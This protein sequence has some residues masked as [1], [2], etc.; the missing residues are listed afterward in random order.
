MPNTIPTSDS[1]HAERTSV[2]PVMDYEP[3]AFG[4]PPVLPPEAA[5]RARRRTPP[6]PVTRT[7]AEDEQARAAATFADAALRRVLE[8]ID[9]RR[10]PAQ[11]RPLLA[12]GLVESLLPRL[13]HAHDRN[14]R[15]A[16]AQLRRV[17]AQP[18]GNDGRAAEVAASY[19][20]GDRIHAIACRVEQL[21]GAR[22][23]LVALH[24]G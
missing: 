11:V 7:P 2:V 5:V 18:V 1:P 15:R 24:L 23:Q 14:A 22:W 16:T 12:G 20:R 3:P 21:P 8:V 9:R 10:P 17:R 4:G 6:H 19:T 13:G